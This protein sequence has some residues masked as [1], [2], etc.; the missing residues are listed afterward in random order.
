LFFKEIYIQQENLKRNAYRIPYKENSAFT[1]STSSLSSSV[2]STSSLSSS[3]SL[4]ASA[5][6]PVQ[7]LS[8]KTSQFNNCNNQS[9]STSKS[10]K[11]I[12][13]NLQQNLDQVLKQKNAI[14]KQIE[15][16]SKNVSS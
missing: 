8:T 16:L 6:A 10:N 7:P 4:G 15:D 13:R 11:D 12:I 5:Y 3:Q 1:S 14:L 2:G 9:S